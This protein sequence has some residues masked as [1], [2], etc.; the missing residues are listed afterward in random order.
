MAEK[1][2]QYQI[3]IIGSVGENMRSRG[4]NILVRVADKG[5]Y[6]G[7]KSWLESPMILQTLLSLVSVIRGK[8][9]D[10]WLCWPNKC[11]NILTNLLNKLGFFFGLL[12]LSIMT[13]IFIIIYH[14]GYF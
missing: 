9:L 5:I 4:N 11:F 3:N 1:M 13:D 12:S 8:Y 14:F 2:N 10:K 6:V 7:G